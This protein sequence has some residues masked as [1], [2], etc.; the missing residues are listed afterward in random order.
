[1][2]ND[3]PRGGH[4]GSLPYGSRRFAALNGAL[5]LVILVLDWLTPAGIVVGFLLVLPIVAM[6]LSD[7]RGAVWW[8]GGMAIAG[9]LVAA[10][11]GLGPIAPRQVWLPNRLFVLFLLPATT[12]LSAWLRRI[13]RDAQAARD[14]AVAAGRM[15]RLLVS[16]LAHDLRAPLSLSTYALDYIRATPPEEVDGQLIEDVDARLRRTLAHVDRVIAAAAEG[17]GS[18][19][20]P[21]EGAAA[22]STTQLAQ[23]LT[24]EALSFEAEARVRGKR[25]EVRTEPGR[26]TTVRVDLLMLRQALALLMDGA[27]RARGT[28]PIEVRVETTAE[29]VRATVRGGAGTEPEADV[30]GLSLARS[31]AE[32]LDGEVCHEG[33]TVRLSVPL[34]S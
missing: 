13:R 33:G 11:F 17:E 10:L 21:G 26:S 1:M 14:R 25:L 30:L 34:G 16:I 24:D 9:F 27:V 7:R 18:S 29:S 12:L 23:E 15:N 8:T 32:H 20:G 6:S 3:E 5:V 2:Q 22:L 19:A 28:E 31:L 4:A